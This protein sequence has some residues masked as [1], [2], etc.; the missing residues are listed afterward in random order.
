MDKWK[1][2]YLQHAIKIF[3]SS[4]SH[5]SHTPCMN[6]PS[7]SSS[8]S[9]SC[10]WCG[11]I[12]TWS[13]S[14]DRPTGHRSG[15]RHSAEQTIR[16]WDLSMTVG[17]KLSTCSVSFIL[18][19][20]RIFFPYIRVICNLLFQFPWLSSFLCPGPPFTYRGSVMF[21]SNTSRCF[22][23]WIRF[24]FTSLDVSTISHQLSIPFFTMWWV[25]SID[26]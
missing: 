16:A 21:T 9:Q 2:V 7:W 10:C 5:L 18:Q 20:S 25:S 26:R 11:S 6:Y 23:Q 3:L 24:S 12:P 14:S 13:S 4:Q 17:N 8:W 1:T 22:G 19:T 15:G